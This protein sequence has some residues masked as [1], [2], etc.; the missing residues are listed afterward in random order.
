VLSHPVYRR[1]VQSP[2]KPAPL[3]PGTPSD[4]PPRDPEE[5][6]RSV[7]VSAGDISKR[8]YYLVPTRVI[9]TFLDTPGGQARGRCGCFGTQ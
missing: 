9:L 8:K 7:Q 1:V 6:G 5:D 2:V 3:L 4:L